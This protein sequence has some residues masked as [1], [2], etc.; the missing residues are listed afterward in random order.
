[1][2]L[3]TPRLVVRSFTTGDVAAYAGIVADPK[4][5]KYLG[6]GVTLDAAQAEAYVDKCIENERKAG[7]A[8]YA[9]ELR[10]TDELMG[11]CGYASLDDDIDLGYRIASRHWGNGYAPEAARAI[12]EYGFDQLGFESIVA[13][14]YS[15]NQRSIRVMEKL[16]FEFERTMT[17]NEQDCRRYRLPKPT[18][19]PGRG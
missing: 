10:S 18:S 14:A 15:E 5:M 19:G 4:V 6:T 8:R 9:L 7:F 3:E 2:R 13:I 17:I 11:F 12:V 16:G 1:M